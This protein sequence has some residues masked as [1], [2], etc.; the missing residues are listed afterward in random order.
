MKIFNLSENWIIVLHPESYFIVCN[1][2]RFPTDF[3]SPA[4]YIFYLNDRH[5]T[6]VSG[7]FTRQSL[8][9]RWWR[10]LFPRAC[11]VHIPG[12]HDYARSQERDRQTSPP[13]R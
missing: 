9:Q 8:F 6:L 12:G 4:Y 2:F 1:N 13:D 11:V 7:F 3:M 5:L 10:T